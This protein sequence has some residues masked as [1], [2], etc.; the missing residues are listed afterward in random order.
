MINL[1]PKFVKFH[2]FVFWKTN[3][4]KWKLFVFKTVLC[5]KK[6]YNKHKIKSYL[7][8]VPFCYKKPYSYQ[9]NHKKSKKRTLVTKKRTLEKILFVFQKTNNLWPQVFVFQKRTVKKT[10]TKKRT[11]FDNPK[12]RT[13]DMKKCSFFEKRTLEIPSK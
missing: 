9:K 4:K 1:K 5:N 13:L 7:D 6:V 2:V 11:L 12:K 8:C 3:T 10:N